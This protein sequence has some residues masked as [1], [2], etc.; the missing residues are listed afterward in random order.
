MHWTDADDRNHCF[1]CSFSSLLKSIHRVAIGRH[2]PRVHLLGAGS[3]VLTAAAGGSR[4]TVPAMLILKRGLP[5]TM[6][7]REWRWDG[8]GSVTVVHRHQKWTAGRWKPV[9]NIS[10]T[11]MRPIGYNKSGTA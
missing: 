7:Q 2:Y 11:T 9:V 10:I 6:T 8:S 5:T 3:T 4:A 1:H